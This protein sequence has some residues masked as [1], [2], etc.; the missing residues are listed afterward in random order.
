[1]IDSYEK[2]GKIVSKIRLKACKLIKN[3]LAIID[4]VEFVENEIIKNGAGIAFPCNVSINEIAAHYTSPANDENKIATGDLVKLDLGAHIDGY[5]ADSA[6]TIMAPGDDL[7]EK[8][9]EETLAK[10]QELIDASDAALEAAISTVRV[11]VEIGKIGA[12]V[13]E[14]VAKYGFKPIVNLTG[15]SLDQWNLHSGLSIPS[16]NDKSTTKLKE[17]DVLAIE[18]FVTDGVGWV[19]D[20]L[21]PFIYRFLNDKPFRMTHTQKVFHE[22]KKTYGSLPFSQRWLSE[23]FNVNRLNAS[24]RQLSQAMAIYPYPALKEKTNSW[25]AQKEHTVIVEGDGCI[26]TTK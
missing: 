24:L 13:E 5:I 23:E 22:I 2:A 17:G 3:D 4:L 20:T 26:I 21:H 16:I 14:A 10:N 1:M 9:D 7:E 6:I 19:T 18:P 11:G 12:A 8:F 25:V 15:H